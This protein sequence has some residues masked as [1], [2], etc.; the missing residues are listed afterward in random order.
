M[1][2]LMVI[3][4]SPRYAVSNSQKYGKLFQECWPTP[5]ETHAALKGVSDALVAQWNT[6][7]HV[8]FIFPL[9]ADGLPSVL[10][11]FL[12]QLESRL[13]THRPT[14]HALINCGFL[15]P[16]QNDLAV[17]MLKLF[18]ERHHLPFGSV[19]CQG[20]GEAILGT[21]FA[22]LC[23]R[24]IRRLARAI[25]QGKAVRLYTTMPMPKRLFVKASDRYW[26][27]YGEK[28]GVSREQMQTM[29]IESDSKR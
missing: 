20:G 17:E 19:L 25:R 1:E 22:F 8:L 16:W 23:R 12:Q 10:L 6:C 28:Y 3:N 18:C 13:G 24:K 9:Y 4:G 2:Q 14:V 21:P 27:Q 11:A 26:T 7:E 29:Q 15:E 5:V